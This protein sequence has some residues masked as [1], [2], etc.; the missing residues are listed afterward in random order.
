MI[1]HMKFPPTIF[2]CAHA[3]VLFRKIDK[4][5]LTFTFKEAY[6]FTLTRYTSGTK[7]VSRGEKNPVMETLSSK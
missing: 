5:C 4:K 3:A 2:L 6:I 1:I 7:R